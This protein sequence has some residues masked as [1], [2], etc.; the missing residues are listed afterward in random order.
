M[1]TD[2]ILGAKPNC[3]K[4][5]SNRLGINPQNPTYKLQSVK[6]I[7]PEPSIFIRDQMHIDDIQGVRPAKKKHLNVATKDILNISDIQ[8]SKS[9]P[10]INFR[11][12]LNMNYSALDYRDVTNADFKT[13]RTTNPLSPTYI[14][15]DEKGEKTEIGRV[16]GS[17]PC[18]LPPER[19]DLDRISLSLKTRDIEGCGIG[20]ILSGPFKDRERR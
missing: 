13:T 15:R 3:V 6:Y 2:D 20:K 9:R 4:F 16:P 19:K 18:V 10:R 11:N 14:V 8:G 5:V 1:K 12:N 17:I 7:E